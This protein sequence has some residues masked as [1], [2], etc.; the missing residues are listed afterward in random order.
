[1]LR[2]KM[3]KQPVLVVSAFVGWLYAQPPAAAP[4]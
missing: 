4:A 3:L 2:L 1:M